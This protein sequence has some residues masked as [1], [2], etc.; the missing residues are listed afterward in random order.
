MP[1]LCRFVEDR[2][3]LQTAEQRKIKSDPFRSSRLLKSDDVEQFWL[4]I[5]EAIPQ[6]NYRL[7]NS[8]ENGLCE[9]VTVFIFVHIVS[10]CH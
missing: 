8:L 2:K 10:I 4:S 7:W 3:Q 1:T 6:Y 5:S 9:Y